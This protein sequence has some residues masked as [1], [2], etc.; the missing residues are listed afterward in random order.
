MHLKPQ[1]L[2]PLC[3]NITR[4]AL[5]LCKS[6]GPDIPWISLWLL[7]LPCMADRSSDPL[8]NL[9]D[10]LPPP[11]TACIFTVS[12]VC[13]VCPLSTGTSRRRIS[14][15]P[16]LSLLFDIFSR[17]MLTVIE[18]GTQALKSWN[19]LCIIFFMLILLESISRSICFSPVTLFIF[20]P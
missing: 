18:G 15:W 14:P 3:Y 6:S 17:A 11:P 19:R 5:S 1:P 7:A 4:K 10:L 8:G 16:P 13:V 2:L 12:T 20:S 9:K